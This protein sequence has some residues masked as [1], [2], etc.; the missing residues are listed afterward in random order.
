[1]GLQQFSGESRKRGPASH[2]SRHLLAIMTGRTADRRK[3]SLSQLDGGSIELDWIP[4]AGSAISGDQKMSN[5]CGDLSTIFGGDSAQ[6]VRHPGPRIIGRRI[7]NPVGQPIRPQSLSR[8]IE[9]RS[10]NRSQPL[11]PAIRC[12]MTFQA[13]SITDRSIRIGS[14]LNSSQEQ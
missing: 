3:E 14:I 1:M 11:F 9:Q 7:R 13:G 8:S 5:V 2:S 6:C 12:S 10:L 4:A